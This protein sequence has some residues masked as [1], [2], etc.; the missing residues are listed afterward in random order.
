MST[1]INRKTQVVSLL[2]ENAIYY[3]DD[4]QRGQHE[5]GYQFGRGGIACRFYDKAY[6]IS[7]KGHGH[8]IP[9]WTVNGWDKKV[10]YLVL[11]FS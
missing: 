3:G 6:E 5:T 1:E 11:S 10:R 2:R 9:L 8:I 4:F 7:I